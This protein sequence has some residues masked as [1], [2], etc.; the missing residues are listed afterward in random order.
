MA[1]TDVPNPLADR[2]GETRKLLRE[3]SGSELDDYMSYWQMRVESLRANGDPFGAWWA[4]KQ[5]SM[6]CS[7]ASQRSIP[8]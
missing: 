7:E 3:L 4:G 6:G 5:L 1:S 8:H 2:T